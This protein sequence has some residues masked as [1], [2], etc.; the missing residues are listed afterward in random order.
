MPYAAKN[1]IAQDEFEGAV[2]I[3]PLQYAEALEGLC[4]GLEVSIENGFKVAPAP[5]PEEPSVPVKTIEE[6]KGDALSQRDQLLNVAAIRIS[7][8]EDAVDLDDASESD[9]ANLK[10]WKQYRVALNR[11]DQQ[12]GFPADVS[13]PAAPA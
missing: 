3:T 8:L 6:I 1:Q 5:P 13:W 12:P 4:N 7:P 2:E 10:K 11:I 9:I